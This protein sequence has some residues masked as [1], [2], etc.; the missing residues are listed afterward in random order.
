VKT[1]TALFQYNFSIY[2]NKILRTPRLFYFLH[3]K[4][5]RTQTT[6]H[7]VGTAK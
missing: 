5:H 2:Q 7:A 3:T 4:Y 1:F 6:L